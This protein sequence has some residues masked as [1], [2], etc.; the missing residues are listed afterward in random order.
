[1]EKVRNKFRSV[2]VRLFFSLC[3]VVIA[4]VLFLIILNNVVLET[5]YLYSKTKNVIQEYERINYLYNQID[6][7]VQGI[8]IESELNK[9]ATKN[10]FD[11][12]I[13]NAQY[14]TIYTTDSDFSSLLEKLY[15]YTYV[16]KRQ[17]F[18]S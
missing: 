8:D 7:G 2:R 1:M 15:V 12:V 16:Y 6:L 11:I 3:V 17:Q 9:I 4:I 10:E 13:E 18:I 14:F 5:F